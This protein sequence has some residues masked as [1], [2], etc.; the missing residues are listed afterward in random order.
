MILQVK[1]RKKMMSDYPRFNCIDDF[2]SV[3]HRN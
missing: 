3:I 1:N 2:F